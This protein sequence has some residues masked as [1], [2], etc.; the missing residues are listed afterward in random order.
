M[1]SICIRRRLS[2]QAAIR[3]WRDRPWSFGPG[4]VGKRALVA[5]SS[6]S[7]RP[8]SAS[9]STS[10]EAPSEYASAVSTRLTPASMA[11]VELALGLG[12]PDVAD[13]GEA[14]AA[15]ESHRAES[16]FRDAEAG[17]AELSVAHAPHSRDAALA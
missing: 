4:P 14:A 1:W 9:P 6:R 3:W 12:H 17:A 15:A 2:S 11:E 13:V 16:Q 5:T 10:S 7:R 8:F